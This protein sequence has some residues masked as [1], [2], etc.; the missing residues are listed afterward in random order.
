VLTRLAAVALALVASAAAAIVA[1]CD[2]AS[3]PPPLPTP[4]HSTAPAAEPDVVARWTAD[5][6]SVV[7][8]NLVVPTN[9]DPGRIRQLANQ[10]RE[11]A[12]Q[13]HAD[14]QRA[15]VVV[16][17]FDST[18]GPER[19]VIGHVPGRDEPLAE[20]SPPTT[21]IALYDFPP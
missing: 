19:Y 6:G 13:E 14:H 8:I 3:P 7:A 10:I 1:A 17:I 5:D 9:T 21:R 4:P 16:R 20:A 18:A 12:D 11:L 15:R 2:G